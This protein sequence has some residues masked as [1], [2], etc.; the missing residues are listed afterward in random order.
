MNGPHFHQVCF[1]PNARNLTLVHLFEYSNWL[2]L[3]SIFWLDWIGKLWVIEPK[4]SKLA[5]QGRSS[6]SSR[7]VGVTSAPSMNWPAPVICDGEARDRGP[8]MEAGA[9]PPLPDEHEDRGIY[10]VTG[11]IEIN[12]DVHDSG[13][14]DGVPSE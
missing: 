12:G 6:F 3:L 14:H 10:V 8:V 13:S 9:L 4:N 2:Q 1:F 7:H 5:Q 11:S